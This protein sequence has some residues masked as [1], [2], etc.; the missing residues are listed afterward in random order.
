MR[1]YVWENYFGGLKKFI[2]G[3]IYYVNYI[4]VKDWLKL[5]YLR[6]GVDEYLKFINIGLIKGNKMDM[7]ILEDVL[8]KLE[9]IL[10]R[11][12]D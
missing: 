4:L 7:F 11:I 5:V 10:K 9:D 1:I 12:K 3:F 8:E 6:K 2:E